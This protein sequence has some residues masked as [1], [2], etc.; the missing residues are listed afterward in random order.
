MND[1]TKSTPK[2]KK[3][4]HNEYYGI[5][6]F[7]D[8]LYQKATKKNSF[9]NLMPI[10]ISD[11]NILLAFRNI[12]GNK[13]SKTAACDNVNIKDIER[14]EQSYFL[15]EVKRRFQNYQPQKVRRKEIPKPNGKTR[16]LGIPSMW[17][18]IIQQCIL[19]VMEPICEAH[20]CNR[21]HGFR[22]NRS[23]ENAIAD[24][25]KRVN[26][27]NLTYVVD[28]DIQG[29]FDEVSH[30]KLMRQ[31][32]TLGIRDKQLLVIIRKIL[33]APVQLPNGKTIFPT[34]GTPQ[35]G[36]LSPL[37]ANVNLNEFD[38]WISNQ[39]ETFKAKKVKPRLKDGIWSNDTVTYCLSKTSKMKPMYIVRYADD[40]KIFTNTRR[41]AEK[42]FEATQM[43]LEERL[44]LPISTEKSKVTNLKKQQ[45]EFLGFTL[46]AV[47][48]GKKNGNTR[49]I[50]VTHISPKALEKT[51]QD[52]AKQVKRIQR[53]PNS[54]ETIKR[55]S[56]YNSMVIGKHNYYKI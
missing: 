28:I 54:N 49:Y 2:N 31:L 9:K 19:Q 24:A 25:T 20:F 23:A 50:A 42:I 43:W 22:P 30:V 47:K 36:I 10:I 15:N 16:P 6:T 38:W 1:R 32:W 35:G 33:K 37:L 39:W 44:K 4:R 48:K 40:F 51:K 55:I 53:T 13:G 7:L 56:I 8:N 14:M 45:S 52:L 27:Q 17:D 41:N 5:Q 3:L 21:S 29:F 34:K 12:K 18:R 46:K 11:E 26:Q